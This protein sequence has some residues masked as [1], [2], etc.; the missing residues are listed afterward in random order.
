MLAVITLGK[1]CFFCLLIRSRKTVGFSN[2][3][4]FGRYQTPSSERST[5]PLAEGSD[6]VEHECSSSS[7]RQFLLSSTLSTALSQANFDKSSEA[8]AANADLSSTSSSTKS[9]RIYDAVPPFSTRR[10][11]KQ[12]TLQNGLRVLLVSDKKTFR[13]TAALSIDGA[14][15]FQEDSDLAGMAHLMEHMVSSASMRED[16]EDWLSD[17]D[18]GSNA[19]TAPSMVCYHFNTARDVFRES[20]ERFSWLFQQEAIEKVCRNQAILKREIRRVDEE[21]D[22]DNESYQTFYLIKSLA[23]KDH[24]FSRFTQGSFDSLQ[25]LPAKNGINVGERLIKFF[26]SHYI[27]ERAVLVVVSRSDLATLEKW[28]QPFST[29]M[30]RA[31]STEIAP[32]S[33]EYPPILPKKFRAPQYVLFRPQAPDSSMSGA[34]EKLSF[35]W[36]LERKYNIEEPFV[37]STT[38][39]FFVSQIIDRRGPG[40]LY[41]FLLNRGWV[42]NG[43]QG[44]PRVSLPIDVSGFQMMRLDFGLTEEGFLNR[45]A[46]I[47]VFYRYLDEVKR[48]TAPRGSFNVP[49]AFLKQTITVA[50][51]HGYSVAPRPSDGV[52]L[53]VDAQTYGVGGPTGVGNIA[54]WPLIPNPSISNAIIPTIQ[55]GVADVLEVMNDS[56]QAIIIVTASTKTIIQ[57]KKSLVD[58]TIPP[59]K[60]PRWKIEP[61]S[62]GRYI[63]DDRQIF[64]GKLEE[65]FV[66]NYEPDELL[67]IVSNPL[68]P[69]ALRPG[70][71]I[72]ERESLD[73]SRQLFYLDENRDSGVWKEFL[74]KTPSSTSDLSELSD[75]WKGRSLSTYIGSKW[76]LYQTSNFQNGAPKLPLPMMPTEA[77]PSTTLAVQLLSSK[78]ARASVDETARAQLWLTS[79]DKAV[80]DLVSR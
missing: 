23:N 73:G 53:A 12:I 34:I 80:A 76:Q 37:S 61:V 16:F 39:G 47:D 20:L 41:L 29:T 75:A 44:L 26:S 65:I 25:T 21:L 72:K 69:S 35:T 13:E 55:T 60:S 36:L 77:T 52:E 11:Y 56:N 40:S 51:L 22:F 30:S 42:P 27:A 24:P 6:Q 3:N 74:T 71:V 63:S 33:S 48:I 15:Q 31:P 67:P 5:T 19:F 9:E 4:N 57:S 17:R 1:Y 49:K 68:I 18:G 2:S 10:Q 78:P 58:N 64:S 14:G 8:L 66:Q 62:A 54:V 59:L 32:I 38:L 7:R 79:F 70:R 45:S 46:V 28:V 43:R 50:Q